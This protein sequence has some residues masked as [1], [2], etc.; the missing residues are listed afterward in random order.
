MVATPGARLS[1]LDLV[2]LLMLVAPLAWGTGHAFP[3]WDD[4]TIW[5]LLDELGPAAV[6]AGHADRPIMGWVFAT[7]GEHGILWHVAAAVHFVTWLGTGV[8]AMLIWRQLFPSLAALS[9]AAGC[10][11]VAP[12]LSEMQMVMA[13]PILTGQL[14]MVVVYGS[15]LVVRAAEARGGRRLAL[16]RALAAPAVLAVA[17]VSEYAILSMIALSTV[18]AGLSLAEPDLSRRRRAWVSIGL[19]AMA[20][21]AGYLTLLGVSAANVR[22]E[23]RPAAQLGAE[24]LRR[25]SEVPL[26]LPFSYWTAALGAFLVKLGSVTLWS[27][28][29]WGIP[30]GILVAVV[31]DRAARRDRTP[32]DRP[33]AAED[34]RRAAFVSLAIVIVLVPVIAALSSPRGGLASRVWQPVQ[35]LAACLTLFVLVAIARS[36]FRLALAVTC[37]FVAGYGSMNAAVTARGI[38]RDTIALG[39][40][41]HKELSPSG[42][43][44]AVFSDFPSNPWVGGPAPR[45]AE[46]TARLTWTWPDA[47]RRRFWAGVYTWPNLRDEMPGLGGLCSSERLLASES[48]GWKRRGRIERVVWVSYTPN[49]EFFIEPESLC[50]RP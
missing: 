17:L 13:N 11:A 2:V 4:G 24:G 10:L 25:L 28:S 15:L 40:K 42:L 29:M 1:Y 8:I 30:Y 45:P 50:P 27:G 36:R 35:P 41:L 5:L 47:D 21:A 6:R 49:H 26:R 7:L 22:P 38:H 43:T 20:A 16:A 14:G 18:L 33:L 44:V 39:E 3:T 31:V 12:I 46:L 23:V 34:G 32:T 19:L 37:G 9:V 48:R